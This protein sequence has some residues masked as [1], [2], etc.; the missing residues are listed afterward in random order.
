MEIFNSG[1][2]VLVLQALYKH[3]H[4]QQII[5]QWEIESGSRRYMRSGNNLLGLRYSFYQ[6]QD[7]NYNLEHLKVMT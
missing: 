2:A 4:H 5:N 3:M 7:E 1:N 6:T